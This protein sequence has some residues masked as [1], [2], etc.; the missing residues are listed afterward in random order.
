MPTY[1]KDPSIKT[2]REMEAPYAHLS[3][4]EQTGTLPRHV[5]DVLFREVGGGY[6]ESL[7]YK[8]HCQEPEFYT[9]VKRL[10]NRREALFKDSEPAEI[11]GP[12]WFH[13]EELFRQKIQK[14]QA[15]L[16]SLW[17]TLAL[18]GYYV[19]EDKLTEA[20][21]ALTDVL[22]DHSHQDSAN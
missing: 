20:H 8:E 13:R 21:M 2:F 7:N 14:T 19:A 22:E 18:K 17:K 6:V 9:D 10:M 3:F 12:P 16:H 15:Q 4:E 1:R 5:Q 11:L